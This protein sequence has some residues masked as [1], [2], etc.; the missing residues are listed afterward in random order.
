MK[1]TNIPLIIAIIVIILILAVMLFPKLF[2]NKSPYSLNRMTFSQE[3][4][5]SVVESAPFAPSK[6]FIFGTDDMGRDIYA[7]I[8]YGARLTMLL[9]LMVALGRFI[10]AIPIAFAAGFGNRPA[11]AFIKIFSVLF[12]AI[13]AVL[14]SI[15]ILKLKFFINLDR[16]RSIIF[17]ILVLSLVG[18][19]KI[20]RL[21]MERVEELNSQPFIKSEVA[22]GKKR[23][24]IALEN[25][26][27]HIAPELI[28]LQL[29]EVA[30]SLAMIMTLGIFSVFIGNL[31][32]VED[33]SWSILNSAS[34]GSNPEWGR[35]SFYNV[36]F[37]PE[38]ASMLS[39]SRS[40]L[41]AAPWAILF[42]ALAF[43]ISIL[44][45]NLLGEGLRNSMQRK[46]S[47]VIPIIRK[48]VT[49]DFISLWKGSR[50]SS[51]IKFGIIVILIA[52]IIFVPYFTEM[53]DHKLTA[54]DDEQISYDQVVIGTHE[55]QETAQ[56]ITNS[57]REAG[58]VPIENDNYYYDYDIESS[59]ILEENSVE[60]VKKDIS[61][62][63]ALNKDF[64]F[65]SAGSFSNSGSLYN[66]T[67]EDLF[68][69]EDYS[70]LENKFVLIDKEYYE[71][72]ALEYFIDEIQKNV[73]IY[74]VVLIARHGE[75]ISNFF[76]EEDNIF[77]M[78]IS[79]D[80]ASQLKGSDEITVDI[81]TKIERIGTTGRNIIG[82][83]GDYPSEIEKKAIMVGMNYNYSNE[84]GSQILQFNLDLMQK[85]CET[86]DNQRLII[87][88]FVD[89]TMKEEYNGMYSV[90]EVLPYTPYK[91]D[92]YIDLTRLHEAAIDSI[93]FSNAL[94]P[95]SRP[96]S[97]SIGNQLEKIFNK[98]SIEYS[99]LDK[100]PFEDEYYL[101]QSE[102]LNLM[103]YKKG[104]ATVVI[105][106]NSPGEK[107]HSIYDIGSAVLEVINENSY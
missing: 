39:T 48:L 55:A 11:K 52:A 40:M 47:R 60:F 65:L 42:P 87:F 1:K 79:K 57:M 35:L 80:F 6:E 29:M 103:F 56:I 86:Y 91:V 24:K 58:V 45:F 30:R 96:F 13:P 66:A 98:R 88:V 59:V 71:D 18:W 68:N 92:V 22:I 64:A 105:G 101:T 28:V 5:E 83:Y 36:S 100:I 75:E 41:E 62:S 44:A 50:A 20:S 16:T 14:I 82:I 89:G 73:Q 43:F 15:I 104:I 93:E 7:Y 78:L 9:G 27:P 10:I 32:Y 38:W 81:T 54:G 25:I 2:T 46:D 37:E 102:A 69:I 90:S 107:K 33:P 70:K 4:G 84:E 3:N 76:I 85:L 19:P 74:G 34:I 26:V 53:N 12:S 51:K 23:F 17:F 77:I 31:K 94:A 106:S 99:E 97:W 21:I 61:L 72:K 49:L 67:R 63:A 8:V 95:F